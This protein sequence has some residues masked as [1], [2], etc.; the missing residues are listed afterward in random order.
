[1]QLVNREYISD[2]KNVIELLNKVCE[3]LFSIHEKSIADHIEQLKSQLEL[4]VSDQMRKTE[5]EIIQK[6]LEVFNE[7]KSYYS[8][9]ELTTEEFKDVLNALT[10]AEKDENDEE[11]SS[12]SHKL[13]V[14][15]P[16]S[17][18][19]VTK[20]CIIYCSR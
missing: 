6:I 10:R 5:K 8:N 11:N 17:I 2:W 18:D 1:M 15:I 14:S 3:K 16:E 7:L 20:K 9:I 12:E 13:H 19:G 4:V